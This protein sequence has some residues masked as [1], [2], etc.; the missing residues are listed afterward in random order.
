MFVPLAHLRY[1][2]GAEILLNNNGIDPLVVRPMWFVRGS[3]PVRGREVMMP[4]LTMDVKQIG[5]LLPGG[6]P[7]SRVDGLLIE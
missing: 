2:D 4:P 1:F 6:V 5:A 7:A 3:E